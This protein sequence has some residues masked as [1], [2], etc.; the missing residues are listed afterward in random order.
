MNTIPEKRS[1]FSIAPGVRK[2]VANAAS[3]LAS[4]VVNRAATF[5]IY[6]LVARYLGAF[7]FGQMSLAL[8]F[9]QTFQLLA[10]AGLE[11]LITREV[12]KDKEKTNKYF[13]N[14]SIVV[15]FFSVLSILTLV[16]ITRVLA[17]TL[18]TTV[19]IQLLS[20]S[21]LPYALTIICDGLFQAWERMHHITYAN[22]LVNIAKVALTI[23]LL[24]QG[25]NL[26]D[27]VILIFLSHVANLLV[28]WWLMVRHIVRPRLEIDV[29]FSIEMVKATT[30]FLGIKGAQAILSSLNIVLLS[31]L[32]TEVEV[33]LYSAA[34]QVLVPI[35]LVFE[36]IVTSIYPVMCKSFEPGFARMKSIVERLLELL[37][38]IVI[39]TVVGMFFLADSALLLLYSDGDFA[40]ASVALRIIVWRLILRVFTQVFGL[41]LVASLRE[42]TTL[43]ILVVDVLATILFGPILISQFGLIGIAVTAVLV[44]I[45]DFI[46]HYVPVSRMLSQIAIGNLAWRPVVASVC[47]AACLYFVREQ[48]VVLMIISG[49]VVYGVVLFALTLWSAGG[50]EQLKRRY[51]QFLSG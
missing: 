43:R 27:I 31:K 21:L 10:I 14:G 5:V 7:E 37:L 23:L 33:G 29:R 16:G 51:M 25:S 15:T 28:K 40:R 44:R 6:T 9:F 26:R 41:V 24:N 42:K 22:V 17:Y 50:V 30:T 36:S 12:A 19:V 18:D 4:N 20:L 47:M 39:P 45:V 11:T 8:T 32:A 2:I 3:M 38:I 34:T 13:V 49:A 46:Q 48:H 1:S 35:A